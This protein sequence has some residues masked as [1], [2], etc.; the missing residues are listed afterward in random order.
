MT[1]IE[2]DAV[3]PLAMARIARRARPPYRGTP[4]SRARARQ[5]GA[6]AAECEDHEISIANAR[7]RHTSTFDVYSRHGRH[8]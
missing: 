2:C 8:P 1:P 4:P 7:A 5:A 3:L 6:L